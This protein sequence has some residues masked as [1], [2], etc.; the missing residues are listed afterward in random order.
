MLAICGVAGALFLLGYVAG[1]RRETQAR[2]GVGVF[3]VIVTATLCGMAIPLREKVGSIVIWLAVCLA[4]ALDFAIVGGLITRLRRRRGE[5]V[6]IQLALIGLLFL[7]A[8]WGFYSRMNATVELASA[9]GLGKQHQKYEPNANLDCPE[10]LRKLY[11]AFEKYA[12]DHD[13]L[14]AAN[15]W[16]SDEDWKA[17]VQKDEWLHCPEVSNRHDAKFGYAFN[18]ALGGRKLGGKKLNALPD[19]AKTP[20][21]YDSTNLEPNAHDAVNS[22][23]RPGRHQ[24]RNNILYCDGHVEAVEPK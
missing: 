4:L 20:L 10:N 1:G 24:G 15:N 2:L 23:P 13:A 18:D 21:L 17:F 8:L 16:M 12:E 22:L 14:P 3:V 11:I 9:L 7:A 19:A 6:G 5:T